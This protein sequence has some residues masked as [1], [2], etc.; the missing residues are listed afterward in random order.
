MRARHGASKAITASAHKLARII[1]H[2]IKTGKAYDETVFADQ[3]AL[4]KQRLEQNLEKQEK[5]L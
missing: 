2:L 1:F 3:E 4:H 5:H